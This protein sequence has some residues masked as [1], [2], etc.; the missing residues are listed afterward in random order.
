MPVPGGTTLRSSNDALAPAQE[1]VALAVALELELDVAAEGE[2]RGELVDLHRVVDDELGRDHRVDLA[3]VAAE[4]L[5][6]VPHRG[7][8][9]DRRHAGEVLV[10]DAAGPEGDLAARLVGRDPA[11][12]RLRVVVAARAERVLEQDA[13]RVREAARRPTVLERVEPE[14]LVGL[15]SDP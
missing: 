11:G 1:R 13:Q 9:D 14:D 6:R 7:E 5:H 2:A 15:G 8:V 4:V 12:D 3:G 10:D